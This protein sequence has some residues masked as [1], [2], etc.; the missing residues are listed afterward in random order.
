MRSMRTAFRPF[1][2]RTIRALFFLMAL[3]NATA[4]ASTYEVGPG[5]TYTNLGSVPWSALAPGDTVNIHNTPGGYHEIVLLSNSGTSNAPITINGVPDPVTGQ[6]P[7]LDGDHAVTATNTPWRSLFFNFEGMIVV[8]RDINTSYG[9]IPSWITIQNL[10]LQN[11]DQTHTLTESD[12]IVTNFDTFACA[13]YVEY[14]QH[15]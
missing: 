6:L 7:V 5:L 9:Y 13:I 2:H 12:G 1:L 14:A 8:S 15:L 4:G 11:A 3:V 10:H